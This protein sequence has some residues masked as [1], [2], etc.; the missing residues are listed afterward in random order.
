MGAALLAELEDV[1]GRSKLF[2]KC[3]LSADEREDLLDIF[4]ASAQWVRVYYGWRPN[5]RDEGDNHLIELA[6]ASGAS[7]IV[8]RNVRDFVDMELSFPSIHI[9]TPERF[10]K[11]LDP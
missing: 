7:A 8:T 10:L 3:R 9:L 6:V 1:L 11:E 2:E 5:L 4:L